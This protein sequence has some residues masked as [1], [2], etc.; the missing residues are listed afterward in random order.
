MSDD[1]EETMLK[2]PCEFGRF[3]VERELG[4]GGMGG[5]YLARDKIDVCGCLFDDETE[6]VTGVVTNLKERVA[7]LTA[8]HCEMSVG[9]GEFHLLPEGSA[10]ECSH[11][12]VGAGGCAS[13]DKVDTVF[14][15]WREGLSLCRSLTPNSSPGRGEL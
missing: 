9:D 2:P 12:V 13:D 14:H 3:I 8:C 6:V 15:Q 10:R 7:R 5:V 1:N 4:H 11:A